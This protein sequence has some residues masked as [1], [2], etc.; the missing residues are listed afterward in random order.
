MSA[1]PAKSSPQ[2]VSAGSQRTAGPSGFTRRVENVQKSTG[3][4]VAAP[5]TKVLPGGPARTK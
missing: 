4:N 2:T 5:A 1:E 3:K